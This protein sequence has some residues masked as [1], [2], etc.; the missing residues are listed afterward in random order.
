MKWLLPILF[1]LLGQTVH[2]QQIKVGLLAPEG[3]TWAKKMKEM[4]DEVETATGGKVRLR[5]YFGGAQGDEHD[6]LRKIRVG[7]LQGGVFTGKTLGEINGDVRVMEIP[8]NFNGNREKAVKA[9]N[10]LEPYF[11][12]GFLANQFKNIGFFELGDV[13]FVA[14]KKTESLEALKGLKIWSWEGDKLV[15][16]MIES[17][18]LVSVPLPITDVLSSLSTGIIEAAYAPG[19]GI[20]AFQWNSRV[21]YLLDLPLSYSI[22]AFLVSAKTWE[23]IAPEHRKKIEEISARYVLEVNESN[24]KD[25]QEALKAMEAMGIEFVKFSPADIERSQALRQEMIEKLKGQLFSEEAVKRLNEL[26]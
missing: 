5:L 2:A 6:V 15:A 13:Y 21:N 12:E 1:C 23:K 4:A 9:L 3:T 26:L 14:Q 16:A 20:V 22:G 18:G 10:Q 11:N 19:M 7:Q 17:L 8:F 24:A 25:N